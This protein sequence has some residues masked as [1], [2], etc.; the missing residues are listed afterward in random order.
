MYGHCVAEVIGER[1]QKDWQTKKQNVVDADKRQKR[2]RLWLGILQIDYS[3][4]RR[5]PDNQK[6]QQR[7]IRGAVLKVMSTA[8]SAV[9]EIRATAV[10]GRISWQRMTKERIGV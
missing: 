3:R 6:S 10:E 9:S 5:N 4:Q 7:L 8:V 1:F 2:Y